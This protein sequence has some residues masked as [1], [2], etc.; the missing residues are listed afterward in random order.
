MKLDR[1]DVEAV[2][3]SR[4]MRA[5]G[6]KPMYWLLGIVASILASVMFIQKM[7]VPVSWAVVLLAF[8]VYLWYMNAVGKRQKEAANKLLREW[9]QEQASK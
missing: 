7:S 8:V 6:N 1:K 4:V 3:K 5:E 2:A 9:Q